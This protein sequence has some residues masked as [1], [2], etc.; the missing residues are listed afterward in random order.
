MLLKI[1]RFFVFFT[2]KRIFY[3]AFFIAYTAML[4]LFRTRRKGFFAILRRTVL[5]AAAASVIC[6]SMTFS[7]CAT[8]RADY[9][10]YVSELR[11]DV[12]YDE[13]EP[14][15]LYAYAYYR[16]SPMHSDG[17]VGEKNYVCEF[18][19]VQQDGADTYEIQ[20]EIGDESGGG[21][22]SYDEVK[23]LHFYSCTLDLTDVP[24]IE[25][26]VRNTRTDESVSATLK[27]A[28]K[29][30]ALSPTDALKSLSE[31]KSDVFAELTKE[32]RN[33]ILAKR[34]V[35]Y[36]EIRLRLIR[37]AEKSYYYVGVVNREK[38][39]RSFL[40]DGENG[41]ILAARVSEESV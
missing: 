12:Y 6:F 13:N 34:E 32:E 11:Y 29:D 39:T 16:E 8:K 19:Y 40:L 15:G 22:T 37:S 35:F 36:G 23:E 28:V 26:C 9:F 18:Y 10:A 5:F 27:S 30:A 7:A 21:E 20:Y 33:G 3:R 17:I 1:V 38:K 4:N 31:K 41:R 25:V 14:E 24:S 2:R